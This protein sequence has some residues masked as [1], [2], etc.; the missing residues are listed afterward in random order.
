MTVCERSIISPMKCPRLPS[1]SAML[2]SETARVRWTS[3]NTWSPWN[4][5][6]SGEGMVNPVW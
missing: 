5:N 4:N 1:D 6:P 2:D 3:I